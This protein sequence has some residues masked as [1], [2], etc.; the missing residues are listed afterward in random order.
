MRT[1]TDTYVRLAKVQQ[2]AAAALLYLQLNGPA[3]LTTVS[4]AIN[5]PSQR[6]RYAL[7]T[8]AQDGLAHIT[9]F[10]RVFGVDKIPR[11]VAQFTAGEGVKA[12]LPHIEVRE[13]EATL[14]YEST[15]HLQPMYVVWGKT[16]TPDYSIDEFGNA[17]EEQS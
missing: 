12:V 9:S 2:R 4:K 17:V 1:R 5:E 15:Q 13:L 6:T 8:L 3:N 14:D 10:E 7:V 16:R 11:Y